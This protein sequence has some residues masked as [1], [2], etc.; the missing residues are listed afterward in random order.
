[1]PAS[2]FVF[3]LPAE[4]CPAGQGYFLV[5][6]LIDMMFAAV[7][8]VFALPLLLLLAILIKCDTAGPALFRQTRLGLN[9]KPFEVL[10]LRTM[11]VQENGVSVAQAHRDDPRVTRIGRFLRAASLD[12]LPQL[13]N[14]LKGEMSLVG[15]R[16]HAVAHDRHFGR[17]IPGYAGR[18]AVK[19]G[20]TGWAQVNGA[21][22]ETAT[23]QAMETRVALDLWY[24]RHADLALD[25]RILLRTPVEV[26]KARN[27][28]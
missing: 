22:G 8:L 19:P 20:I 21:R 1:M 14:V 13:I 3:D 18:Q 7:T 15:P 17:V 10:K 24:V 16:P 5:K 12:E 6:R 23:I 9:G 26:L 25:L 4:V 28:Y 11:T 2:F 27:A